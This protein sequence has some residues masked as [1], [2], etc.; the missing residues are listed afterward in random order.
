MAV[1]LVLLWE[2]K[3]ERKDSGRLPLSALSTP[4]EEA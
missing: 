2:I 4:P 3:K 1:L